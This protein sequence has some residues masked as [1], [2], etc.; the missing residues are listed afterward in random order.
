MFSQ[1]NI[2]SQLVFI[3]KSAMNKKKKKFLLFSGFFSSSLIITQSA[4]SLFKVGRD[5]AE[6][7]RSDRPITN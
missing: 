5:L 1:M 2:T 3:K 4:R 7:R 6:P